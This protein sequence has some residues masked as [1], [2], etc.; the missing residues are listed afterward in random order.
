M[1]TP[2][3]HDLH[4]RWPE[5]SLTAMCLSSAASLLENNPYLTEIYGF[6]KPSGWIHRAHPL[7]I[8]ENL[9]HGEYDLGVLLTNSF[10]SAWWFWRGRVAHRIGFRA[11][12]RS[13]LLNSAVPFPE[14]KERQHL[15]LTYK[16]LLAPLGIPLSDTAPEL[17]V[18]P[19]EKEAARTLL[20]SLKIPRDHEII[21]INPGAAYGSAKCWIPERFAAVA[22]QL[23]QNRKRTVLFFGDQAGASLIQKICSELDTK[24]LG[25]QVINLAGKTSLRML[26]ALFLHC[27]AILT[28]DSG[29][30]HIASALK[31]PLVALF[32][33]TSPIKTGPYNGGT[34]ICKQVECSPCYK[35]VCPIDFRCMTRI[36]TDEVVQAIE[37]LL[38]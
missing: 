26:M 20:T 15:V 11:N 2:I 31:I 30:M 28:N 6:K 16:A 32:G 3:L 14:N 25:S 22:E 13:P 34:V 8:I 37:K 33:S 4:R 18:T 5:A 29:P 23:V 24:G 19:Q 10:S 38:Q 21:G 17:F 7:D 27:S 35:R 12:F 36:E 1:A 9:Q